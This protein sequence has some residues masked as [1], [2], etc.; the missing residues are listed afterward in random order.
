MQSLFDPKNPPRFIGYCLFFVYFLNPNQQAL[1]LRG[2][3]FCDKKLVE[4]LF[5]YFWIHFIYFYMDHMIIDVYAAYFIVY[6]M[7]DLF[8]RYV[9]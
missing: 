9:S 8:F 6:F 1:L 2:Y 5:K 4:I 3:Y 7:Y